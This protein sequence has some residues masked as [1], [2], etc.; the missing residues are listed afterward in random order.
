MSW[1]TCGPAAFHGPAGDLVATLDP[2]TEA[3]PMAV[4]TQFLVAFGSAVGRGPGAAVGRVRHYTNEYVVL[5]GQS[6]KGRKG[7]S[8]SDA[9]YAV[10]AADP[11]WGKRVTSGLSS[12]EGLIHEVR[13]ERRERRLAK[14][15]EADRADAEGYIDEVVDFGE[16]DKRL[17]VVE[18]EFSSLLRRMRREGNTISPVIREAFDGGVLRTMTKSSPERA[19]GAHVSIIGHVT[20][21]ELRRELTATDAGNGFANRFMFVL[22]KRSKVLPDGGN[23]PDGA[24]AP[25]VAVVSEALDF[26]RERGALT[27]DDDA[28][29]LWHSVYK[30]LSEGRPGLVGAVTARAEAHALR[31]S[32]LYALLDRSPVVAIRHLEA[33]LALWQYSQESA[34]LI[35]GDALGDPIADRVL[36]ELRNAAPGGLSRT[37]LRDAFG[38]NVG[39]DVL[40]GAAERLVDQGFARFH[41]DEDT[42]GRPARIY[43]ATTPE[44]ANAQSPNGDSGAYAETRANAESPADDPRS[45]L[46]RYTAYPPQD[47]CGTGDRASAGPRQ[48]IGDR[49]ENPADDPEGSAS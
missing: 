43:L 20:D 36:V 21:D 33:A 17:L 26:A 9:T 44:R 3:D 48:R 23:L 46:P 19:T 8:T 38:R 49:E 30:D 28:R 29:T 15:S 27:R 41:D 25:L 24:L 39:A 32:T 40:R 34:G 7:T 10:R 37:G 16:P 5:V 6:A 45:A 2:H 12:A 13:D 14:K 31:L 4:L 47:G 22:V 11:H 35:F 42:G 1:P 18:G